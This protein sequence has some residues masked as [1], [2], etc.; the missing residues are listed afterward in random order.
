[1]PEDSE[2]TPKGALLALSLITVIILFVIMS[3]FDS[4]TDLEMD[5]VKKECNKVRFS[6]DNYLREDNICITTDGRLKLAIVNTGEVD[7]HG[8]QISALTAKANVT[9]RIPQLGSINLYVDLS[10]DDPSLL[11]SIYFTP[12]IYYIPDKQIYVCDQ[13]KTRLTDFSYCLTE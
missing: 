9:K 1:M 13:M 3:T 6:L 7:I 10:L 8:F 12:K 2:D 11:Q 4:C 5:A